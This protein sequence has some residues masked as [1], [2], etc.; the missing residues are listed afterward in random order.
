T[1]T[2][3]EGVAGI[4]YR[5]WQPPSC[6]HPTIPVDGPLVFDFYDTWMERSLGGG[7]Y[8]IGHPGGN[9]PAAFPINAY[10]AESRRASRFFKMG[11]RGGKRE[12]IPEEPNPHYPM[13]LDLRRNRTKTP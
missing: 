4:R 5:A 13:T 2:E 10:E 9:N 3:G 7:T 12:M 6:L 8:Y 1:G 11:H